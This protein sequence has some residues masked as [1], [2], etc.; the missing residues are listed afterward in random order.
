M[1]LKT[2]RKHPTTKLTC[3]LIV[4]DDLEKK[5]AQDSGLRNYEFLK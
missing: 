1:G 3:M 4:K 5:L 2:K